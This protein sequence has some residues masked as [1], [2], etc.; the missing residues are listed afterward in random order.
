MILGSLGRLA[1]AGRR[2]L[3]VVPVPRK[4]LTLQAPLPSAGKVRTRAGSSASGKEGWAPGSGSQG[5]PISVTA[6]S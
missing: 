6:G 2:N 3:S 4:Q 1:A 5:K